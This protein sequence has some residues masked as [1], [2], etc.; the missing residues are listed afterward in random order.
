MEQSRF[1]SPVV[2][3]AIVAQIVSILIL[4]GVI[5]TSLGDTVNAV[6]A[7]VFQLLVIF[8]ILN[9]PTDKKYF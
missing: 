6:A 8:G 5:E 2:W 1:K 3:A 7:G 4:A 9:N